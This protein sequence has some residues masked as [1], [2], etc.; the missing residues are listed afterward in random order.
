M[1]RKRNVRRKNRK[2]KFSENKY[3]E[4]YYFQEGKAVIPVKLDKV[5]DLY[6]KHDYK[7]LELADSVCNYIE[8]I[9]YMIPIRSA[10]REVLTGYFPKISP[11][12]WKPSVFRPSL[13][14]TVTT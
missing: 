7:Q 4:K 2:I 10:L 9:A 3:V 13:F 8:E 6:M 14:M 1:A 5:S 12:E 11:R